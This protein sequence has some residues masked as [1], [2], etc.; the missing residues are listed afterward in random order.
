MM[1]ISKT[2]FAVANIFVLAIFTCLQ[3]TAMAEPIGWMERYALAADREG[4]LDEL[5]P[6]SDDYYFYHCLYYQTSGQLERSEAIIR[7]WLAEHKGKETPSITSMIDRQRLLTYS[8]SPQRTIDHLIR[9][10]GINLR[11]SPP[12]TKNERRFPSQ[13]DGKELDVDKLVQDAI[14]RN[15]QLKPLGMR[16]L[17]EIFRAGKTAGMSIDLRDFLSRVT[18]PYIDGL[19]ELVIKELLS[20]RPNE[21]RFGDLKAHQQLT[22]SELE[23]IAKKVPEVADDNEYVAAILKRMRPGEDSDPSQ[24][25]QVRIDYLTRVESYLRSLPPSYNS[26]KA[27]ATFRLLEANLAFGVYD[28]DLFLRYLELP[29]VSPIVH[30]DWGWG[31]GSRAN[32]GQD[33]MDL[34]L[35]PAVGDEQPVVR[36]HLEHF[37]KDAQDTNAFA[38][39]LQPDYL[40]RVFAETKLLNGIGDEQ[41][42]YKLLTASQRQAIRDSVELRLAAQNAS[43]FSVDQPMRLNVDLKNLDELVVR[44]YE[45]NTTSYYRTHNRQVDTDID[46]DGLI[47]TH[48][49]KLTFNQPA[50]QRHRESLEFPEIEGRGVW[51]VD[52]VGKGVR[53]RALL[54]RGHIDHVAST[55]ANGM[56]FTII[57]ENRNPIPA[58]TMLVGSREFVSDDNGQI[59]LPP[60]ANSVSRRAVISDGTISQQIKFSHLMESY[61]LIAG[62]HL[63]RSQLQ[64]GGEAEVVIRPQLSMG[65]TVIDPGTL[66]NV[67]VLIVANDLE[68][69]SINHQVTDRKLDQ[70]GELVIP[71]RVPS[72]LASLTVTL[73]GTVAGLANGR[74]QD[75]QTSRT[76]DVAGIRRTNHTLDAFLTRDRDDYVIEVRGRNGELVQSATVIVALNTELRQ[77][78]VETTLQ[79]DERGQI[80]LGE[81]KYVDGIRYSVAG[82]LQHHR[83]LDLNQTIWAKEVHSTVDQAIRLPL[84]ET[85]QDIGQQFRLL[86]MHSRTFHKDFT[87]HLK[88]ADG[89]LSIEGLPAGDFWLINRSTGNHTVIAIV[90]GKAIDS[91]ATGQTRHRAMSP[92][93]PLGIASITNGN[94]GLK[95]QLSGD[96]DLARVH[97]YGTRFFDRSSPMSQ[98]STRLPSL[99]GRGVVAPTNGYVSDLRLGD[100]YQYVLRRRYA[101]KYAGVMLPQ[102]SILL[103][104]WETEETANVSQAVRAGDAPPPSAA[105]MAAKQE[106]ASTARDFME[107]QAIASD[108]DFLADPGIV[109]TNLAPDENGI[110]TIPKDI[111]EGMPILQVVACDP[112]TM[113][114]RTITS[115][116]TDAETVDLRL[117][118]ALQTQIPYS[119]ERGV[120]VAGPDQPVDLAGLGTAQVQV[121]SSVADLLKLYNTLVDDSRLREFDELAL[122]HKLDQAAKLDAYSRLASHELHLFLW[123]HDRAFFDQ[124]VKSYLANKPEKQ[125][126]D[127]WLLGDDLQAY[128]K[129]WKYNQLNA[130]EKTLLAIRLPSARDLVQRELK[131]LID[132]QDQDYAEVRQSIESALLGSGMDFDD[133]MVE[134]SVAGGMFGGGGR[135]ESFGFE[136]RAGRTPA[137]RK[138]A[139]QLNESLMLQRSSGSLFSRRDLKSTEYAFYQDLDSTKQWAESQWDRVRTVGGPDPASLISVNPF[140]AD[141]VS[142]D[143]GSKLSSHLLRPIENRHAAL[144]ALAMSGLPLVSGDVGLPA[145]R[146]AVYQPEHAVA[147]VTKSL[148]KLEAAAGDSSVLIGQRFQS[149]QDDDQSKA[150]EVPAEPTEFLTGVGYRGQIV[151]SN[152]TA[153]R[154]V[155][156]L[157]WQLPAGSL[158]LSGSQTT[159][160]KTVVLEPFAVNAISYEFYFPVAGEFAH[161]PATV[162][163]D[164]KLIT[165]STEKT[166]AVVEQPTQQDQITWEGLAATGTSEQIKAFLQSANLRDLNWNL[167]AH[168]MRDQAVYQVVLGVLESANLPLTNLWAYSLVHQDKPAMQTFLSQRKDLINSVGP[169]FE[170]G[171]LSV[172]P[173]E[174]RQHELLEYAPLV[175]ARIHRLGEHDEI[176]NPTFLV[177]Y[178]DFISSLAYSN[179]VDA[180]Q[181]LVLAYYLL[182]QNRISESVDAFTSIDRADTIAKLQYDYLSAYLDMHREQYDR[183][184]QTANQYA[185]HPIP[186]WNGRFGELLRQL[187]QRRELNQV[188]QLVSVDGKEDRQPVTQGSGDLAV[189]DRE[190]RQ[191][192]S[193]QSQPEVIVRVEGD[194]LRIDHRNAR[195]VQL[196]FYGVDL[197]LLFSKAP[198]VREDLQRMAMVRPAM[199]QAIKFDSSTGVGRYELDQNLRRQ[200]V[201][202]EVVAGASRSTALYY[203]GDITTYVSES[204]GQLQT[205]DASSHRPISSAYVK[206]YGKYP[207]GSVRFYKDGYTDSRGRF[208][209]TSVSAGD[210]KGATRYAIL[211]I[212]DEKGATLH[213]VAAPNQ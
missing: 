185:D 119:F 21:K 117:A 166:F 86:A 182:I 27:S 172:D 84:A 50:V 109:L 8:Q 126:V 107:H 110:V 195:E 144:V 202:V 198:F 59:V 184:E 30:K 1:M 67:K 55:N 12:A 4:L 190:Q 120:L 85:V 95:I 29:R 152:P 192:N 60:V 134:L 137:R 97:F 175:R 25:I 98:L 125:F 92:A 20:R 104:P 130:S 197:E 155:I 7:D 140:W 77:S 46:L 39:Y 34:A 5:I 176:L 210:A 160:S 41:Q 58:A 207:D 14:K 105:P 157:F 45:I 54:R 74:E 62:M 40:R 90:D 89:L 208:D 66:K 169:V 121:Y 22:L 174:Q 23:S 179:D 118:Q 68:N 201:L 106:S 116:L 17:A 151:L 108:F 132:K 138:K 150:S 187:G 35:L 81:L 115:K 13:L 3:G 48:E 26:M 200:T 183:A 36:A 131:E 15:D 127:H 101:K 153:A 143:G 65:D 181:Q 114:Q 133:D 102:P 100:E 135:A 44:V 42:W 177:Q 186:R 103:N 188:E 71:I 178:R 83:D 167:V 148:I 165:Q 80:R 93:Q 91:V 18:G 32:L 149:L 204:F 112:A 10:L 193:S 194:S 94:E 122:W 168:R 123:F 2:K 205:T 213:D 111:I 87:D 199:S 19:D 191:S 47:A 11:H 113:V 63:D 128:T 6:G 170:S 72:R 124:F 129:L 64:S 61:N 141:L 82:G 51:V 57:D 147:M 38:T 159:D 212:S 52:L 76:W 69:L 161:Y 28:R 189:L 88:A 163:S 70:N 162:A 73:T 33:F 139:K 9:R 173:I 206:V 16:R 180:N 209:Y 78:P 31:S 96:T 145:K 99:K 211:V 142:P 49:K 146:D 56:V 154:R 37:L 203:G 136:G 164:G 24:Q 53:A 158:P 43:R 79:S 156:D 75:L 196:N 171:L